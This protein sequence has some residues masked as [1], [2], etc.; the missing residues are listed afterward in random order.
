MTTP[1]RHSPDDAT[2]AAPA[3]PRLMGPVGRLVDWIE[4]LFTVLAVL[5]LLGLATAVL[6]QIGSRLFLP[7]SASWT[8]ELSR[9]LF[10]YMVAF[11]AGVVL[12]HNRNVSVEL[13]P[14][15]L[16]PRGLGAYQVFVCTL[17]GGFALVVLPYAWQFARNGAWQTSPTLGMPMFYVFL[18]TVVLFSLVLLHSVVG[19]IEGM[20]AMWR[21]S[22]ANDPG[23]PAWK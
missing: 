8:E 17:T 13:V 15:W 23:V 2:K 14:H 4:R 21:R 22:P 5:A 7:F 11:A 20:L 3:V 19:A 18:A 10:I 1:G 9:Y 12:R 16:G 6:V